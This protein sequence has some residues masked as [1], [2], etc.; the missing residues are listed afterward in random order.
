M[1]YFQKDLNFIDSTGPPPSSVQS[2][3]E[4]SF[5]TSGLQQDFEFLG[6]VPAN[7]VRKE[8]LELIHKLS[9]ITC[10]LLFNTE[11]EWHICEQTRKLIY[12]IF[13]LCPMCKLGKFIVFVR[14][15]SS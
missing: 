13:A 12:D 15:V 14:I 7:R 10:M 9:N 11:S 8:Q 1:S 2:A 3:F 6:R 5:Q 4:N